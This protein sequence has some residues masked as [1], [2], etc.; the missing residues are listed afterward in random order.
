M[1]KK[2]YTLSEFDQ[3]ENALLIAPAG[4]GKT[5][6]IVS[7][8]KAHQ[9]TKKLLILTHTHAGVAAV[10][11][12]LAD[13]AV[14]SSSYTV[15]TITSFVQKYVLAFNHTKEIPSQKESKAYYAYLNYRGKEIIERPCILRIIVSTYAGIFVDEYQDCTTEQ[16]EI[17][18]CLARVLPTKILGDPLQ[19]IFEFNGKG[20]LVD[21]TSPEMMGDFHM[22]CFELDK[23]QRWLNGNNQNLG[24]DLVTLRAQ[25]LSSQQ[26]DLSTF[27][28]IEVETISS[29]YLLTNKKL[30]NLIYK[31]K[32]ILVIDPLSHSI[33]SRVKFIQRFPLVGLLESIDDKDF[34]RF[35]EILDETLSLATPDLELNLMNIFEEVFNKTGIGKWFNKGKVCNRKKFPSET[36]EL[37]E[38]MYQ[39]IQTPSAEIVLSVFKLLRKLPDIKCYRKE[40]YTSLLG[41]MQ[42]A[43]VE[44]STVL[45]AMY[46]H[47]NT[48]RATGRKIS[49]RVIGTTLLT[50]GLECDTVVVLNANRFTC[51]K[52]L[53]VALTRASKRLVVFTETTL[54][55]I[56]Y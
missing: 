12:R 54:L 31:E 44:G 18:S 46:S 42:A 45:D 10:K 9:S 30:S 11:K 52:N 43:S 15:E 6:T 36:K 3:H 56:V 23:P 32:N 25:L 38:K 27:P 7:C 5:Y 41:A 49:G 55:K 24:D 16:H 34:Y 51:P 2:P 29:K 14:P 4:F 53:Y 50:K 47:R 22:N 21:I 20:S 37:R 13:H 48:I 39:L 19:G 33:D 8:V 26:I 1:N 40:L 17:I 35:A 28:S